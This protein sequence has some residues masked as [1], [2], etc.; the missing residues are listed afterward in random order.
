MMYCDDALGD[1]ADFDTEVDNFNE[2]YDVLNYHF[3][4]GTSIFNV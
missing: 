2:R 1:I 4:S 3:P